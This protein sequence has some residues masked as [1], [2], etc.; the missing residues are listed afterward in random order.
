M[1]ATWLAGAPPTLRS[2]GT[3][4]SPVGL[5]VTAVVPV[6]E[7]VKTTFCEPSEMLAGAAVTFRFVVYGNENCD[8]VGSPVS[9]SVASDASTVIV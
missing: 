1:T 6:T 8:G 2:T 5:G 9:D 7:P 4:A 3:P